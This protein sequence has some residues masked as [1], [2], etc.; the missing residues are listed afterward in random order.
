MLAPTIEA[1]ATEFSGKVRVGK[2]NTDNN[3]QTA[4]E[5]NISSIPTV[6]VFKS[7]QM[8]REGRGE[9]I[10]GSHAHEFLD[11]LA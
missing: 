5:Y 11:D 6:L 9:A 1:L 4:S 10:L 3:P 8:L 7:G 2:L